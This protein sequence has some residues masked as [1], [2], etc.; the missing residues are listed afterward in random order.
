MQ[1]TGLSFDDRGETLV[2]AG[3]DETFRLY[4]VKTGKYVFMPSISSL[5]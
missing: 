4:N 3:G 5:L 2:T 1:I